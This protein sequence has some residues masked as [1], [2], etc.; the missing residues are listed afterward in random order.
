MLFRSKRRKQAQKTVQR[1]QE[2]YPDIDNYAK[3]VEVYNETVIA[4]NK[5]KKQ[6]IDIHNEFN[7]KIEAVILFLTEMGYLEKE[8]TVSTLTLRGQ[9][10]NC[11]REIDGFLV[12][13]MFEKNIFSQSS[14]EKFVS[15]L[16]IFTPPPPSKQNEEID[17]SPI[18][19]P[20]NTF[21]SDDE[22][23]TVSASKCGTTDEIGRAHV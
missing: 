17:D 8:Q 9:I 7:D 11:V 16:S 23:D 12:S 20:Y 14:I 19:T 1:L 4:H 2:Q 3:Q 6:Y 18:K 5:L 22:Y 15:I 10:V 21:G 13:E